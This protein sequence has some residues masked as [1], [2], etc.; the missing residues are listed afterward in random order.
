M[1]K[2]WILSA[3]ALCV[4]LAWCGYALVRGNSPGG[5][6]PG[7]ISLRASEKKADLA[8]SGDLPK[9][10]VSPADAQAGLDPALG[11]ALAEKDPGLRLKLL[12]QWADSVRAVEMEKTLAALASV[13][14]EKARFEISRMLLASWAGRDLSGML[15]WFARPD[16]SGDLRRQGRDVLVEECG[17]RDPAAM[18]SW[19]EQTLPDPVRTDLYGPFFRQWAG[20]DPAAAGAKLAQL[21]EGMRGHSAL[22]DNL[23]PQVAVEWGKADVNQALAWLQSMPRG[24]A[25]S[26]ALTQT[27]QRWTETEPREAAAYASRQNAPILYKAVAVKWAETDPKN[28]AAWAAGLPAGEGRDAALVNITAVWAEADPGKMAA[29]A[30]QFPEGPAREQMLGQLLSSWAV[31]DAAEAGEWLQHLPATRSRDFAVSAFC[32]AIDAR[33]PHLSFRW[34]GKISDPSLRNQRLEKAGTVWLEKDPK[35]ARRSIAQSSLPESLKS[36]LLAN[37]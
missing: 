5:T 36:R 32:N 31:N 14:D 3:A 33:E 34:A 8:K 19:M 23:I 35:E 10:R 17:R 11:K 12:E 25:Q 18:F 21:T 2:K 6:E 20:D 15:K 27:M 1:K 4:L 24:T 13:Q 7:N 28:A 22:W 37:P 26:L 30:G 29:W 16:L 9:N